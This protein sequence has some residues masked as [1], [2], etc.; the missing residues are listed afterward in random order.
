MKNTS[1][2]AFTMIAIIMLVIPACDWFKTQEGI[3]QEKPSVR[4]LDLNTAEVYNDAHIPAAMHVELGDIDDVSKHWDK[5]TPLI[6]YCSD[7]ACRTSHMA[8]KKL[9]AL[10]FMDVLVYEGGINEWYRLSKENKEMYPLEGE[11][12]LAF[13]EKVVEK[14][15]SKEE[16]VKLITAGELAQRLAEVH[17]ALAA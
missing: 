7:Y 1:Y 3:S 16:D 2:V 11:A 8:A 15:G 9:I 13:L 10:G 17:K 12:K 14:V 4:V 6:V 5:K